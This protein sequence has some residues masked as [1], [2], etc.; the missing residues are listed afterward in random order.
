MLAGSLKYDTK[1]ET[2]NFENGLKDLKSSTIAIGNLM[3]DA[4]EKVSSKVL[5]LGSKIIDLGKQAISS[6]A[7]YEQ[8]TGGAK[9]IFDE[10]D[11]KKISKDANDAFKNLG[12][13]ANQY[14]EVMNTVGANFTSTLGDEKGYAIAKEGLQAI[15]DFAT[16]TGKSIDQLSTKYQMITRSTSS[17]L[18]IADQFAGILPQTTQGFLEQAQA[19][20]FLSDEY[21]KIT[22]IP[23]AEY[24]EALT[25][26]LTKG[27]NGLGLLGN[28]A[29]EAETTLSGSL[30]MMK[31][32]WSNL[33]IGIADGNQE[34]GPLVDNFVDSIASVW[35]NLKPR[36]R[37]V[38][39]GV[40]K[41]IAELWKKLPEIK[42]EIPELA[43]LIDALTWIKNNGSTIISVLSGITAG[44]VA[45][46]IAGMIT[47]I[48]S[49]FKTFFAI[50]KAGQ[51]IMAVLNV[52]MAANPLGLIAL[53][54]AGL[55]T[56]F[57]TL[58]NTSE[59][60][61]NF[62]IGLWEDIENVF[63]TVWESIV[64][65]FTVTIPETFNNVLTTIGT[66]KDNVISFFSEL[67]SKIGEIVLKVIAFLNQLP[68]NLGLIVGEMLGHLTKFGIDAFNWVITKVPEIINGIINFFAE[69]PGKIWNWL[70]N[71][72][73]KVNQW[74]TNLKN[75]AIETGTNF[76]N[77]LINY[78]SQL[79]NR[80]WNLLTNAYNN[81]SNF[82]V[83]IANKGREGARNLF[84]NVIN[85]IKELPSRMVSIGGDIVKGLWNGIKNAGGWIKDKVS[86]F[87]KG[88]LDGMKSALGIHSPS[89]LFRD[90]IGKN[91]A[92][93]LGEGFINE[94]KNV[95]NK[96]NKAIPTDFDING[97]YNEINDDIINKMRKAVNIEI[98]KTSLNGLNA[99]VND[100]LS[101]NATF[102]GIN[103]NNLYLDGEKVYENQQKIVARKNLQYGGVR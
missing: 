46:K 49:G 8:L 92:L 15:T 40:K 48:I 89:R 23:I 53:A 2:K 99:S 80:I 102:E 95:T 51:G 16:G 66:W 10:L 88:I 28:T 38:I 22:D 7:D 57:I 13:S 50:L 19:S 25:K 55:I 31:S 45:F 60:F 56:A 71:T 58:W 18:S 84:N 30:A 63:S 9:K 82:A 27:V 93:G 83:N 1:L 81:V 43:P 4:F 17:Y 59:D 36:I 35:E 32:A 37:Q 52:V 24:Q 97:S 54:V 70:I 12:L 73:N 74:G 87:A 20:G 101:A 76:I 21:K 34:I 6:Y 67:P 75:K 26:M 33:L 65:F 91:I 5:Q 39:D 11:F 41:I 62:W 77:N 64:N 86:E 42:D 94:M 100:M 96:M 78:F 68:Y 44:F 47:T 98:G 69:L 85:G 103:N 61:K 3:S 79:P 90:E 72:Y 29:M 14:L